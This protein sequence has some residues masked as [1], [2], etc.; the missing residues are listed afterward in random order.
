MTSSQPTEQTLP[1]LE[2][3]WDHATQRSPENIFH[4]KRFVLSCV[5]RNQEGTLPDGQ[6]AQPVQTK[7][8]MGCRGPEETYAKRAVRQKERSAH[9]PNAPAPSDDAESPPPSRLIRILL[10][11]SWGEE[12]F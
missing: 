8:V 10:T 3:L 7:M 9:S 5:Y 4:V 6:T 12:V 1:T 11:F 2:T